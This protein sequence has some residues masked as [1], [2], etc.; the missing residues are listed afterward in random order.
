MEVY[1]IH[2]GCV[3]KYDAIAH[4]E[5]VTRFLFFKQGDQKFLVTGQGHNCCH[6]L[7]LESRKI[8]GFTPSISDLCGAARCNFGVIFSW[9]SKDFQV[10]IPR[11][12]R[13]EIKK[14]LG[15]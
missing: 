13:K 10:K 6:E 9:N 5:R 8:S 4:C 14:A 12:Y 3:S 1:F 2:R 11:K 7:F 15:M